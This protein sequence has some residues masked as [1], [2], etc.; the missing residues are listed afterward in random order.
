MGVKWG[1]LLEDLQEWAGSMQAL[2]CEGATTAPSNT[3]EQLQV[4]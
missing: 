4:C 2:L 3:C 1:L